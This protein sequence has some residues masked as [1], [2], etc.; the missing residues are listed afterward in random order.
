MPAHRIA[1]S[2]NFKDALPAAQILALAQSLQHLAITINPG[3]PNAE[4][5]WISKQIVSHGDKIV[6]PDTEEVYFS[7]PLD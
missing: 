3:Q 7:T 2:M 1:L 4:V 5:S 6:T